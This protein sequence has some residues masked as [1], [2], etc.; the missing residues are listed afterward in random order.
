MRDGW[1]WT[2]LGD[3]THQSADPV[4]IRPDASYT[5]LGLRMYGGGVFAREEKPG[6]QIKAKQLFR[7]RPGQFIYN[8]L[9][10][11][12]GSFGVV[13]DDHAN[14]VVSNEFPTF[15]VDASR[16]SVE[17]L[18]LYFQRP[19]VWETVSE[20]CIG[21]TQTRLRWK[22]DR[23]NAYAIPLP[24]VHEQRR[25]VDLIGTLDATIA[26][27]EVSR[28]SV[29]APRARYLQAQFA[30][31]DRIAIRSL[32]DGIEGGRSP[33][34]SDVP[35]GT[36]QF[37]VLKVSAVTALGFR[38]EE[39]KTV[40]DVSVFCESH[41]VRRGDALITRANTA[42]L[43]GQVC[44]V[45][46]DHPN[47]FLCDKTLR[48]IP[49]NGVSTE[50]IVAALNSPTARDQLSASATGTSASMKNISQSNIRD[51][52]VS[53]PE[54]PEEVAATDRQF[55]DTH[56]NASEGIDHMRILRSNLLSALLS[57]EHEIPEAYDELL[58][59]AS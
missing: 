19:D 40:E 35:P 16:L 56:R 31:S 12:G 46:D 52:L 24:P 22:E 58:E 36:D 23:F 5:N 49:R 54:N 51:V 39:S 10:A 1:E 57:G 43:V 11:G 18:H 34:A 3:I 28:D 42:A 13:R 27:A 50:A 53:W 4:P 48:L 21:T 6:S 47:L 59:G 55:L 44:L 30:G 29:L 25:I 45:D 20:Q 14:G 9:F 37:G 38:P 15:D 7:V 32:L 17:Y 2:A 26:A 33:K 8:R 41:R